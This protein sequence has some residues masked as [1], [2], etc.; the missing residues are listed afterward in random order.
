MGCIGFGSGSGSGDFNGNQD[1]FLTSWS[2]GLFFCI[3]VLKCDY[4]YVYFLMADS[5][6]FDLGQV[7]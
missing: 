2:R 1:N 6:S 7:F 4:D 3:C 5:F